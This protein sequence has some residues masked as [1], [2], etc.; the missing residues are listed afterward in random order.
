[1]IISQFPLTL[2]LDLIPCVCVCL[3]VR[4]DERMW[5][6]LIPNPPFF[7][8]EVG[9]LAHETGLYFMLRGQ[10]VSAYDMHQVSTVSCGGGGWDSRLGNDDY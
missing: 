8:A 9:N 5:N 10:C 4:E 7:V 2:H 1:M 6:T 3:C